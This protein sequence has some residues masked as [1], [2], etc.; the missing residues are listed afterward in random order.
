MGRDHAAEL[1]KKAVIYINT[2]GNGRGFLG[3]EGSHDFQHLVNQV[4]A[5]VTDPQTGVSVA[6]PP[7]RARLGVAPMTSRQRQ[8]APA[9][10]AAEKGGDLPIGPLGSGSDY[11]AYLQHLGLP[12]LNLGFGGEDESGRRLPLGLRQ[13][14]ITSRRSTIPA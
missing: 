13:L 7:A 5:D 10:A 11:S 6:R 12:A 9:L 2:D 14:S 1:K 8:R 3:A 4:A